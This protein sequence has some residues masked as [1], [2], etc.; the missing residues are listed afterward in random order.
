MADRQFVAPFG[1]K[2]T[3]ADW[4]L[5]ASLQ[6]IPKAAWASFNGAFAAGAFKPCLR[7]ISDSGHVAAEAVSDVIVQAGGSADVSW[8]PGVDED[9]E[10]V[11]P[12]TAGT[13][14]RVAEPLISPTVAWEGV[15]VQEPDV[16]Y[17][18]GTWKMWYS[19]ASVTGGIGY[20]SC[21]SDPTI[22]ANWTKFAGNPVLG[23][24]GSGIA[25]FSA[26]QHVRKVSGT[27]H[28]FYSDAVGGG[29]LKR[30][31][32]ANGTTWAAPTTAIASGAVAGVNGWANSDLYFDG[33]SWFLFV[34]GNIGAGPV[35]QWAPYLFKNT[36]ITGDGAWV[37]QNGGA[38]LSS[39]QVS[40]YDNGYGQGLSIAEIDGTDTFQ[41]GAPYVLWC[42]A[43]KATN[44]VTSDIMHAYGVAPSFTTWTPVSTFDLL[45][46]GGT[47]EQSQAADPNVLQVSGKSYLFFTGENANTLAGYIN[48]ATF[49]GTLLQFLNGS[50]GSG[51]LVALTS[52]GGTLALTNPSGPTTNIEIP[53][54]GVTA[55][56]YGDAYSSPQVTVAADGITTL[57][58]T[59]PIIGLAPLANA[60]IPDLIFTAA[61]DVVMAPG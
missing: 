58:S 9:A 7:I 52:S 17:E 24:G 35:H 18:A 6:I 39:L 26:R 31:T 53:P 28:C 37:V 33:T 40:G 30:S 46:N 12:F 29:N 55:A 36:A 20:A 21:T 54:S 22:P 3:P 1:S 5:P 8:F 2:A 57:A 11:A 27:Y 59:V 4:L 14:T 47:F 61:G 43:S 10:Q 48:L 49:D 32:S 50:Q 60:A 19:S 15:G 38:P 51:T 45:H 44:P 34:E 25:G 41:L 13:W 23:A 16:H 56:T 42:H